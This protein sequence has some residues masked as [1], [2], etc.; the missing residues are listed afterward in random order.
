MTGAG[1]LSVLKGRI[2]AIRS[3]RY[4]PDGRV[5]AVAEPADFV[6]LYNADDAYETAQEV[7]AQKHRNI[8]QLQN[9]S[10][11]STCSV[12]A[13]CVALHL[14][15]ISRYMHL[16]V[17][18]STCLEHHSAWTAKFLLAYQLQVNI[19]IFA[20]PAICRSTN[21][22]GEISGTSFSQDGVFLTS[23]DIDETLTLSPLAIC[24]LTSLERSLGL[25]SARTGTASSWRSRISR[26]AACSNTNSQTTGENRHWAAA[27]AFIQ[28]SIPFESLQFTS[29]TAAC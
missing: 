27:G 28:P 12:L 16:S 2:G 17:C 6:T 7:S 5:L 9:A 26:T 4:S 19:L 21:L 8:A 20:T 23:Q 13:R 1:S 24:R 18:R 3:L 25:P 10:Q 11:V 22:L 14:S 29:R 15:K